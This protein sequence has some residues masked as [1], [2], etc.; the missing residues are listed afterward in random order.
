MQMSDFATR[1]KDLRVR[2]GLRQKDLAVALGMAQTTIANYEQK[3]RFPD[4][5]TL[6]KIADFFS[7]TL[8]YLLGRSTTATAPDAGGAAAPPPS[9]L[10]GLALDYLTTLRD[11]GVEA[12]RAVVQAALAGGTSVSELYLHVF[13]PSLQEVGRL[14]ERGDLSVGDEHFV[15]EATLAIMA[16]LAPAAPRHSEAEKGP[17]ATV[18]AVDGESHLIGARMV[19]D[20]LTM[21]GFDVR[22]IGAG[23][24]LG[25]VLESLRAWTPDLVA[26][27]VTLPDHRNAAEELVRAIRA[28]RALARTKIIVGGQAFHGR[29]CEGMMTGADAYVADAEQAATTA[30]ALL[31]LRD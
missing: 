18:F 5:P 27:S 31:K 6:V 12:A 3:L 20:F 23:L 28:D 4:E 24:S 14:W 16:S 21:A 17:R 10:G 7:I 15:S 1:L 30:L 19:A 2:R 11:K 13:A 8:D 22:F 26:L 25:H 29:T 9:P